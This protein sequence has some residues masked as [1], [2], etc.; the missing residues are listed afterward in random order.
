MLEFRPLRRSEDMTPVVRDVE[1]SKYAEAVLKDYMPEQLERPKRLD[2]YKFAE[3][4]LGS[5]IEI[6]NIYTDSQD[7]FIAGAAVFN[8]QKVKIFN[9]EQLST[10][11]IMV[12][13]NT[14]LID[15]QITGRMKKGFEYFTVMH[16]AGHL[17]MHKEVY[18]KIAERRFFVY[19]NPEG[20]WGVNSALCMRS[21][22]GNGNKL[23]TS[24]DFREHQA[25]TFAA[26]MLMPPRVFIPYVQHLIDILKYIDGEF[27]IYERGVTDCTRGMIY[28]KIV[29]ETARHFGVSEQAVKVQLKKYGL[30]ALANE[31]SIYEAKRRLK[32][33]HSLWAYKI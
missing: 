10:D 20:S 11:I 8:P 12:P 1:I 18:Q 2:V 7:D 21:N 31:D 26:S 23:A 29:R 14:I 32:M 13:G 30:H 3:Q 9:K 25:N 5:N 4:Y 24:L 15:E 17:M 28:E 16:E 27:I 6:L 19:S 22:I 33:Y